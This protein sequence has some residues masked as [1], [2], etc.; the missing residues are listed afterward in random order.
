[1]V[2]SGDNLTWIAMRFGTSVWAIAQANGLANP[3]VIYAGQR[4][5]IPV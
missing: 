3:N 1:V 5:V 2:H 4:L